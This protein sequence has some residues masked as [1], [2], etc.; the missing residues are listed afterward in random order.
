MV[1]RGMG[2]NN[3]TMKAQGNTFCATIDD[4]LRSNYNS[5]KNHLQLTL[6]HRATRAMTRRT[7]IRDIMVQLNVEELQNK[8]C[9]LIDG[10]PAS[11]KWYIICSAVHRTHHCSLK[12]CY[13]RTHRSRPK[14]PDA[15][16]TF[17]GCTTTGM[18]RVVC[19]SSTSDTQVTV[20]V[21]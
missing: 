10:S 19:T 17:D 5:V 21:P 18:V 14:I 13:C 6:V 16:C 12:G 15:L 11:S 3:N 4:P 2:T 1:S 8:Y 20:L 9:L 7:R